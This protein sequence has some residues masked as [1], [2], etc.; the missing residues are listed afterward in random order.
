MQPLTQA[1]PGAVTELLRGVPTSD[2]KVNFAW[3]VAVG[4]GVE[5]VSTARLDSRTLV[6]DVTDQRWAREI[7]R[8]SPVILARLQRLLGPG[9]VARIEVRKQP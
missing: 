4:P 9:E 5:R 7:A 8:S 6:V 1:L 2:G 3:R